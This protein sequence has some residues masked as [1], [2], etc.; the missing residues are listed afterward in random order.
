LTIRIEQEGLTLPTGERLPAISGTV[1]YWRLERTL[2]PAVLENV[3]T[4]GF[5]MIETYVPWNVHEVAPGRFDWGEDDPARDLDAFLDLAGRMGLYVVVRPGPHINAE[6]NGFGFPLRVLHDPAVQARTAGGT[7]ALFPYMVEPFPVPSYASEAFFAE[8]ATWFDAAFGVINRH[9]YPHGCVVALQVDNETGY[10]FRTPVFD[11]DYAPDSIAQYRRWLATRYGDIAA[12]NAAYGTAHRTFAAVEPPRRFAARHYRELPYYTDWA[13]YREYYLVA[14]LQRLAAMFRAR[15][16][17]PVPLFQNYSGV[18]PVTSAMPYGSPYHIAATEE[19]LDF[20]GADTYLGRDSYHKLK[21]QVQAVVGASRLPAMPEFGSGVWPWTH[22]LLPEDE[23]LTTPA[24]FMHGLKWANLYMLHE[25]D[26]WSGCPITRSNGRRPAYADLY[27]RWND[28]LDAIDPTAYQ[29]QVPV[30]LLTH[31]DCD[32]LAAASAL[33][34]P[35]TRFFLAPAE[36]EIYLNEDTFGLAQPPAL[37]YHQQWEAWYGQLAAAGYPCDLPDTETPLAQLSRYQALV[38]PCFEFLG[39]AAQ[40]QL[41]AYVR[42]GGTLVIGPQL[43]HLDAL[44]QPCDLLTQALANP[45]HGRIVVVGAEQELGAAL[46]GLGI[47][48]PATTGDPLVD[49]A[50]HRRGAR[51]LVYVANPTAQAREVRI[52][53]ANGLSGPWRDLWPEPGGLTDPGAAVH[54]PAYSVRIWEVGAHA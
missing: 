9:L 21:Q 50:V 13:A 12:L 28:L 52:T 27:R 45:G 1:H 33:F 40:A 19:V 37:A 36:P 49:V 26:R 24:A 6:L 11:L 31:R 29:R 18:P 38:L 16:S 41:A 8:V 23:A 39:H 3:R 5:R 53:L 30:A 43:P 15:W 25:R 48:P 17:A 35:P 44:M 32:R 46:A 34:V 14:A 22:Q 54:L 47:H 4:L 2:W 42:A 51:A 10:F 7:V 20:C